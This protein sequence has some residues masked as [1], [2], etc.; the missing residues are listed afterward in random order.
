MATINHRAPE[1]DRS[2]EH[3]DRTEC[4]KNIIRPGPDKDDRETLS[5]G[6]RWRN[7]ERHN[8]RSAAGTWNRR[9]RSPGGAVRSE[10]SADRV[11]GERGL[12]EI[13]GRRENL[14]WLA[15]RTRR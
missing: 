3:R 12:L 13:D 4:A 11:L 9:W 7:M 1:Q 2:G 10:K 15:R 8:R 6:R 14:G 5:L